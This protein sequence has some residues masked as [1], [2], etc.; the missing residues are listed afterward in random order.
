ML[1]RLTR[2]VFSQQPASSTLRAPAPEV[3]I[4]SVK[5]QGPAPGSNPLLSATP[6][7]NF[8]TRPSQ[9]RYR[10]DS[11]NLMVHTGQKP[12]SLI[13]KP[14]TLDDGKNS[15]FIQWKISVRD[16]MAANEVFNRDSKLRIIQIWASTTGNARSYLEPQYLAEEFESAEDM[17]ALLEFYFL[18]SIEVDDVRQNFYNMEMDKGKGI[19]PNES[20]QKFKARFLSKAA[21][22]KISRGEWFNYMWVKISKPLREA[23]YSKKNDWQRDFYAIIATLAFTDMERHR[24]TSYHPVASL[25]RTT[26]YPTN[27]R[28]NTGTASTPI[29]PPTRSSTVP[30]T[31]TH[32]TRKSFVT[33]DK[34]PDRQATDK[35]TD[36]ICYSCN[37][38]EHYVNKCFT[39]LR[40]RKIGPEP[41][42]DRKKS[43]VE[44]ISNEE[45]LNNKV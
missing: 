33:K 12:E 44:K 34:T 40:L 4:P 32:D 41:E 30:R 35:V 23:T 31:T 26:S 21:L 37:K 6:R 42:D 5:T 16:Y 17:I 39:N 38:S 27:Q 7:L 18:T 1:E 10:T 11:P 13:L 2:Q 20:F 9:T 43:K 8:E 24:H 28:S 15:T 19:S 14:T 36:A 25:S 29:R 3:T 45:L 22:G